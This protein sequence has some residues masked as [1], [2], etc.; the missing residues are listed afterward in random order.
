MPRARHRGQRRAA[1]HRVLH[2]ADDRL[3]VV[4][5]PCSIHDYGAAIEYA[6]RLHAAVPRGRTTCSW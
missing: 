4:A 3:V 1:I 6:Q 5:G 2:G